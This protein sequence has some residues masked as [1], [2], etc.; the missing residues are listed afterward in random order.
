MLGQTP[1]VVSNVRTAAI[2]SGAA[3]RK[4]SAPARHPTP[5]AVTFVNG[6]IS[7]ICIGLTH[8]A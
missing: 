6:G 4:G 3:L 2:R 5:S 1:G 7:D 8:L